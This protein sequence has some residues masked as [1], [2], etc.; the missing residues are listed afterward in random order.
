MTKAQIKKLES[1]IGKLE[2]LENQTNDRSIRDKL[3]SGK[4]E[5]LRALRMTD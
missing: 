3:N 2:M 5:L 1:I 4:N